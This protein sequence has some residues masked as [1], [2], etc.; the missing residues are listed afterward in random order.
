MII[1]V[2]GE[3]QYDV[4]DA[5]VAALQPLDEELEAA[6]E[7]ADEQR[8]R[9]ALTSLLERIRAVGTQVP[10]DEID[11]SDAILPGPDARIEEVQAI[12][13][14]DGVIPG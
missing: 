10:E 7:A 1:R 14:D 12:L 2:L 3:G 5:A 13:L 9:T 4:D 11:A 6:V 8:F